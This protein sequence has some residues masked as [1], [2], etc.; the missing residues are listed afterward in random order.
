[1][2]N[3]PSKWPLYSPEGYIVARSVSHSQGIVELR[4]LSLCLSAEPMKMASL[5]SIT[6]ANGN[7]SGLLMVCIA[8]QAALVEFRR[9]IVKTL[10]VG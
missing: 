8:S 1:M 5:N 6:S 9:V 7:A 2:S 4:L 3:L 10:S